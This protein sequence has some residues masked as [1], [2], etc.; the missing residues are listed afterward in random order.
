MSLS[1]KKKNAANPQCVS[2]EEKTLEKNRR[3]NQDWTIPRPWQHWT[4]D[5][6]KTNTT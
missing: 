1:S 3:S 5:T 6:T 2:E 4:L